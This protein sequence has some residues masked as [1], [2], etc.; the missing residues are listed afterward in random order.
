MYRAA[1]ITSLLAKLDGDFPHQLATLER[2]LTVIA[3]S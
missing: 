2:L 1:G 3:S